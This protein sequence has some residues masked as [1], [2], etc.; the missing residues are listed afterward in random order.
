MQRMQDARRK[1]QR[2]VLAILIC[3][4][5]HHWTMQH[6]KFKQRNK[7]SH[8]NNQKVLLKIIIIIIKIVINAPIMTKAFYLDII[9][10]KPTD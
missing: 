4:P 3:G 9:L 7:H 1:N 5:S 2:Q 10:L 8:A 6:K